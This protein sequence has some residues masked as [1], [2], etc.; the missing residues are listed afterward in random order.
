MAA[1]SGEASRGGISSV[2]FVIVTDFFFLVSIV[3]V[4]EEERRDKCVRGKIREF[5]G[6]G[7]ESVR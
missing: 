4:V 1:F 6:C 2:M 5:G 3:D 7:W